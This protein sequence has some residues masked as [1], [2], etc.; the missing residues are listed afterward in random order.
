MGPFCF[1]LLPRRRAISGLEGTAMDVVRPIYNPSECGRFPCLHSLNTRALGSVWL[2]NDN[3]VQRAMNRPIKINRQ[4]CRVMRR[5]PPTRSS[6]SP[7]SIHKHKKKEDKMFCKKK[8]NDD[9]VRGWLRRR[10][11]VKLA[12]SIHLKEIL[13]FKLCRTLF[14]LFFDRLRC[15]RESV[16]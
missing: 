3:T 4:V 7:V 15:R 9:K 11:G 1:A 16:Q 10:C 13:I 5:P 8:T 2:A 6:L 14:L 12:N